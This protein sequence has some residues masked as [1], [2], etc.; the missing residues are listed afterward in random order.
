[1]KKK[2]KSYAWVFEAFVMF[3]VVMLLAPYIFENIKPTLL[4][5]IIWFAL[6]IASLLFVVMHLSEE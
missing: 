3:V 6:V 1:M 4:G 5:F 2:K